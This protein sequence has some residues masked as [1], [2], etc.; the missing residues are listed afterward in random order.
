M[1]SSISLYFCSCPSRTFVE[2]EISFL[3]LL[4]GILNSDYLEITTQQ[5][6]EASCDMVLEALNVTSHDLA[7]AQGEDGTTPHEMNLTLH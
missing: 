2:S 3:S 4:L 5:L 6:P 1:D 7:Q